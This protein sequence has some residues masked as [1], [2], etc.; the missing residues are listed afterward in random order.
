MSFILSIIITNRTKIMKSMIFLTDKNSPS[1]IAPILRA[2][3]LPS[4]F[5]PLILSAFVIGVLLV[6]LNHCRRRRRDT[7]KAELDREA[8]HCLFDKLDHFHEDLN[9]EARIEMKVVAKLI[10]VLTDA[11]N[12]PCSILPPQNSTSVREPTDIQSPE[13]PPNLEETDGKGLESE[14]ALVDSD[15][16]TAD[17]AGN[18]VE[19]VRLVVNMGIK[20]RR[21]YPKLKGSLASSEEL[22]FL[23][24]RET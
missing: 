9:L 3:I 13:E 10:K 5:V 22:R 24:D 8:I 1:E 15:H 4:I 12:K 16:M 21:I 2:A 19:A 23:L 11:C 20:N 18:Y 17:V 7:S 14:T 6:V